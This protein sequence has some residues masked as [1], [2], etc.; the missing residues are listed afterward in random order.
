MGELVAEYRQRA[1]DEARRA[2]R[3]RAGAPARHLRRD[4]L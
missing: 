4:A 1:G 2:V 3:V